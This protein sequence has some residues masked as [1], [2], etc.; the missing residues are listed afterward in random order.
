MYSIYKLTSPEG[1]IYIGQTK[2][3]LE[4]RWNNGYGYTANKPLYDDIIKFGWV[5]FKHELL[6]EVETKVEAT[7]IERAYIL[8][9]KSNDAN[10]G[11]NKHTNLS[12]SQPKIHTYIR[13][14]ET[15]EL[16]YS[17]E[18]AGDRYQRTRQAIFTAIKRGTCCAGFHWEKCDIEKQ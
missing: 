15:G 14:V 6:A 8:E 1:K 2:Q 3:T 4:K 18:Q 7:K 17:M 11:Y 16:F 13:C 12:S 10:Y 9:Y 5:N